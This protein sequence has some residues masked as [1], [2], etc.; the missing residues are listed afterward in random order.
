MAGKRA[1]WFACCSKDIVTDVTCEDNVSHLSFVSPNLLIR[2]HGRQFVHRLRPTPV[3]RRQRRQA[4]LIGT[5]HHVRNRVVRPS[6]CCLC[7]LTVTLAGLVGAACFSRTPLSAGLGT[8]WTLI[9]FV[10]DVI[11]LCAA[12]Q[13]GWLNL[14][15]YY[16][17]LAVAATSQIDPF[18]VA[19]LLTRTSGGVAAASNRHPPI[20]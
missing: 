9:A 20:V 5:A 7:H 17:P 15:R 1:W 3:A 10:L 12:S 16:F 13:Y 18:G 6:P 8:V 14:R 11:P 19:V 2:R 4:V